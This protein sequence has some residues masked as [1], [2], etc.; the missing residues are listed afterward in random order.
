MATW[1]STLPAPLVDGYGIEPVD[2]TV[3]TDMEVGTQRVRRRS[4]AQVDTVRFAVNLSDTQMTTFRTWFYSGS[5]ADGG[6]GWFNISLWVGKGGATAA[7]ARFKGTP[8]WDMTGNHRW[9]VT[10]QFEVRYA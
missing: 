7:E 8:K 6:A 9:L 4:F 2:Q 10:G 3:A 5:D 1:H